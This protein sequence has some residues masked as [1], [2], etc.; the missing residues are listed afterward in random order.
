[1]LTLQELSD[2]AEI[3][4]LI[5]QEASAM[6]RRDWVSWQALFT[7]HADIDYSENEGARGEPAKVRAWLEAVLGRF[8]ST[9]HSLQIPRSSSTATG[10]ASAACS[11]S[12]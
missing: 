3:Q 11:T 4:D 8:Q 12:P 9:Q 2:R 6:D 5:V 10:R 7:Q 1:M